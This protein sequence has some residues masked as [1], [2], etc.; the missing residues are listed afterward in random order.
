VLKKKGD[1]GP[2]ESGMQHRESCRKREFSISFRRDWLAGMEAASPLSPH[3]GTTTRG[4]VTKASN[5]KA[6][7]MGGFN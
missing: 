5:R 2:L 1:D 3:T 4:V 6:A 7:S